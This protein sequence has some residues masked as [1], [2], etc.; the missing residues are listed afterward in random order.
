MYATHHIDKA[1]KQLKLSIN[2]K[3]KKKHRA[4][5]KLVPSPMP[6]LTPLHMPYGTGKQS[7]HKQER[8]GA[9]RTNTPNN[10]ASKWPDQLKVANKT[11]LIQ[12]GNYQE[13]FDSAIYRNLSYFSTVHY[14]FVYAHISILVW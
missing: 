11:C 13:W 2:W 12:D 9:P 1:F 6:P 8:S 5:T 3:K 7:T 10:M 14:S 4:H